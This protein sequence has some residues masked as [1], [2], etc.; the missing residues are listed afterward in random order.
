MEM[1]LK[2]KNTQL[3]SYR[4]IEKEIQM[5]KSG[6]VSEIENR[7][8]KEE[9]NKLLEAEVQELKQEKKKLENQVDSFARV[10]NEILRLK[11]IEKRGVSNT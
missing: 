3:D 11:G 9:A 10:Q 7:K 2:S 8:K 1:D 5:I 6:L 4:R